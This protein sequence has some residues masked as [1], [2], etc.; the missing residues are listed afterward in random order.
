MSTH[1]IEAEELMAYFDGGLTLERAAC[2]ATHVAQ[3]PECQKLAADMQ[4]VSQKMA[5][6]KVKPAA[7]GMSPAMTAEM[8][9]R[10][11]RSMVLPGWA[12]WWRRLF[13]A[14]AGHP[15]ALK[16]WR[17]RRRKDIRKG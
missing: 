15:R 6:W 16:N 4:D 17:L 10:R 5:E 13:C 1:F 3:C 2:I 14:E 11:H 8:E 7:A 12:A 9:K